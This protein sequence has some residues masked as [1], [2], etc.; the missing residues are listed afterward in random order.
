M[1]DLAAVVFFPTLTPFQ[2][3]LYVVPNFNVME[4]SAFF[5]FLT[6]AR[7]DVVDVF[8]LVVFFVFEIDML[9]LLIKLIRIMTGFFFCMHDS[10]K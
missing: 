2:Y 3:A 4:D 7:G 1:G 5:F 10:N 9:L 6:L 8:F